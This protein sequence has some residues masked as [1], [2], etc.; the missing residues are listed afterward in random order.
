MIHE[1][2]FT[3]SSQ[4]LPITNQVDVLVLGGGVAGFGAAYSASRMGAKTL[5]LELSSCV[6]GMSTT[7]M[8]SH[9]TGSV[10]S[11]L[12]DTLLQ[13]MAMRN[14]GNYSNMKTPIIDP[15]QLKQI[16]IEM[17]E[18][19][20]AELLLYTRACEPIMEGNTIKGVIIENKSGRQVILAKIVIDATGDGDIAAKA[21]GDFYL[22]REDDKK[23]QPATLMFKVGGVDKTKAA[24]PGSFETKVPTPKGEL[25]ALASKLLPYPAGHVLLYDTTLPGIITCNMTNA[26]NIDGT[27]A[28][29]L[30]ESE[31]ICRM[32]IPDII[33]FLREYVPGFE[34]CFLVSTAAMMGIRETRHFKGL[35]TLTESDIL[36]KIVFDDW[37][38]RGACFNFDV[39]NLTGAS[40]D[41]TGVQE[42]FPPNTRYT[43][44]YRCL[45]IKNVSGL[46]LAGRN[47]SG[48]HMAHS[49]FR[50]MPIC[51]A[52]GEG[53]G[54]AAALAVKSNCTLM[55]VDVTQVQKA[56][57]SL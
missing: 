19:S 25:Q 27:N 11:R 15:E 42:K 56:L 30:T 4:Q 48:T 38:V 3:V 13:N 7:G 37:I 23:M 20:G 21:G 1:Q 36:Q 39:H 26:I 44:P 5:M 29:S 50:A 34:R 52:L 2:L 32:Q 28:A 22:G 10:E 40:L 53:A 54:V 31:K 41:E 55:E 57:L 18:Q 12:F 51:L 43:I 17:L 45:I 33:S 8:M 16:Y 46:L 14:E 6:G 35:Y 49:N 9:F 47:I 24:L